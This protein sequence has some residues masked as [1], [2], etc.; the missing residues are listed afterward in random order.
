MLRFSVNAS[1]IVGVLFGTILLSF[2]YACLIFGRKIKS[3]RRRKQIMKNRIHK[4]KEGIRNLFAVGF[5]FVLLICISSPFLLNSPMQSLLVAKNDIQETDQAMEVSLETL[6]CLQPERWSDLTAQERKDVL[7]TIADIEAWCLGLPNELTVCIEDLPKGTMG[8]YRDAS[9]EIVVDTEHFLYSDVE[10]ILEII[11]HEVYHCYEYRLIEVYGG[12]EER[13]K[14][15]R[16]FKSV[17]SYIREFNNY[18]DGEED[19]SAYYNQVCEQDAREYAESAVAEYYEYLA[20]VT[21]SKD[22]ESNQ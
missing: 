7:Q 8:R 22:D 21:E 3:R 14:S 20:A 1:L 12:A 4:A 11:C 5:T 15:L 17:D 19:Y 2:L 9:H 13:L 10:E 16:I 6:L 18:S